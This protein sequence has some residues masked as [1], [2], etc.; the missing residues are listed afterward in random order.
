MNMAGLVAMGQ[1]YKDLTMRGL[2]QVAQADQ[3]RDMTNEQIRGAERQQT[4]GNALG[5]A[6]LG[7]SLAPALGVTGPVGAGI[8]AGIM[9]LGSIFG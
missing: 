8:G 3:Q 1:A 2:A 4:I 7:A 9:L 6:G 5:G